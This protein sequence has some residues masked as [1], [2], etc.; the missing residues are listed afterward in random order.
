MTGIGVPVSKAAVSEIVGTDCGVIERYPKVAAFL[1]Q[2]IAESR[3][4]M[5]RQFAAHEKDLDAYNLWQVEEAKALLREWGAAVTRK[6]I[7]KLL[8]YSSASLYKHP[9]ASA[10]ASAGEQTREPGLSHARQL[11]VAQRRRAREC[12]YLE[13]VM[14]AKAALEEGGEKVTPTAIAAA[15]GRHLT[16]LCLYPSIKV[17][18]D[19]LRKQTSVSAN[20][21]EQGDAAKSASNTDGSLEKNNALGGPPKLTR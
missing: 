12:A 19:A 5:A 11:A 16:T 1:Q 6:A 14:A 9:R 17:V 8:Q 10:A 7:C 20:K 15:V 18:F 3:V 21:I 13:K 2:A 4:E